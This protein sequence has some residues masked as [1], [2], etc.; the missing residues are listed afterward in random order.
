MTFV[1]YLSKVMKVIEER[2]DTTTGK[3]YNRA[4]GR[5]G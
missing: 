3:D 1:A 5:E 4:I 2:Q